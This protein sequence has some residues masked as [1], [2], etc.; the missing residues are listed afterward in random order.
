L[1]LAVAEISLMEGLW[2]FEKG[3]E[4]EARSSLQSAKTTFQELQEDLDQELPSRNLTISLSHFSVL[5][6]LAMIAHLECEFSNMENQLEAA[7]SSWENVQYKG[8]E[9]QANFGWKESYIQTMILYAKSHI[10]TKRQASTRGEL[11]SAAALSYSK[12]GRHTY[13]TGFGTLFYDIIGK[14]ML[15]DGGGTLPRRKKGEPSENGFP[16]TIGS[17]RPTYP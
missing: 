9:F 15:R 3:N 13:L 2:A 8:E 11:F 14:L 12:T 7:L 4:T 16:F 17:T 1:K 6:G 10:A 5:V